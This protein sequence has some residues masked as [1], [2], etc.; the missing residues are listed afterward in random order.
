MYE[1]EFPRND[2]ALVEMMYSTEQSSLIL[3][4]QLQTPWTVSK[5]VRQGACSSP[6]LFNLFPEQLLRD[7]NGINGGI[8][9]GANQIKALFYADDLI[10]LAPTA[11]ELNP[12][13]HALEAWTR[14][15]HLT[16]NLEKSTYT[17]YNQT[18][19]DPIVVNGQAMLPNK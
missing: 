9:I 13:I 5:G 8:Q 4:A 14:R 11:T 19:I 12:L 6:T 2:V 16:I 17:V 10:L 15:F 7:M 3:N 18:A 1:L